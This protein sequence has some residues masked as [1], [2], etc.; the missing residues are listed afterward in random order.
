MIPFNKPHMTGRELHYI[1]AAH[2]KGHLAG[3]GEFTKKCHAWFEERLGTKKALL[4][5]SCT[6]A[7]EM[8]AILCDIL[9]G[10]EV[11]MPSYTFVSTANAFVLRGGVPVFVDI[12]EDNLNLDEG[13]IEAAVTEKTRAIVAVHY[14]GIACEMDRI[15]EI[16]ERHGLVVIE[17]AAQ[18]LLSTYKGRYLGTIGHIGCL[19]FHETKNII[20]GEGGAILVND[21]RFVERAEII[22]EKGTN[23][24]QFFRGQV[25]KYTWVDIGS[26]YLPS[27]L[28]GAFLYAQLEEC[29]EIIERR[30]HICSIYAKELYILEEKGLCKLPGKEIEGIRGNGH[31]YY[32]ILPDLETRSRLILHLKQEGILSVFHYV[33]LHSSPAGKKYARVQGKMTV[34]EDLS[35]RLLR[36]PLYHDLKDGETIAISGAVKRLF[37]M[38]G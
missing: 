6:A 23:R 14:A 26:S 10:D 2:A 24:S 15:M 7:L 17:D 34:T 11:I 27:E 37:G 5:H 22:R 36:L 12:R 13:L 28:I 33:P 21:E 38:E 19:S 1:A 8:A 32:L 29:H 9:P 35:E 31:M 4:T 25:D 20:S 16:A 30:R 3:D 18:A